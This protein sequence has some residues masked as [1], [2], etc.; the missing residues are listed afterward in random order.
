MAELLFRTPLSY[1]MLKRQALPL[2]VAPTCQPGLP[3]S[4]LS[5]SE[6]KTLP[7][8]SYLL[9]GL[10]PLIEQGMTK[11]QAISSQSEIQPFNEIRN[12]EFQS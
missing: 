8:L 9:S 5:T 11:T 2:Y 12:M 3:S 7:L 6:P 4:Q 10:C 1:S